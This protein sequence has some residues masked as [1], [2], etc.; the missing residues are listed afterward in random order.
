VQIGTDTKWVSIAAGA[1]HTLGLKSD[2]TQFCATGYNSSGQLGYCSTTSST[3]F[4]C[5]SIPIA[6]PAPTSTTPAAN[7]TICNG[8]NTTLAAT[9]TGTL[10]WY[11]AASAGTYIAGGTSYTTTALSGNTTYYVQDSS[12]CGVA[13][14]TRTAILVTVNSLT[15]T[16]NATATTVCAGTSVTLTGS[17]TATSYSWSGTVT[18]GVGFVPTS[19][20]NTYTVT[21][22]DVNSCTNT[23][24]VSVNVNSLPTVTLGGNVTQC[25][26]SVIL[27][28]GNAGSTYA[29]SPAGTTQTITALSSNTYSVLVTDANNCT[30]TS[31]VNITI[32]TPPTVNLGADV[33]QCGGSVTL[34][35]GNAGSTYAWSPAGTTQTITALATNTYSVVVTDANNCTG[36]NS[37]VVTLHT[38]PTVNLGGNVTQ[39]GGNVILNAG[40]AGSTYAWSPAGTTQTITALSSNTYSVLVTDVNNCTGTSTVNITIHTPPTVNLGADVTQ[41]GGNVT[42]DAGNSGSTYAWSPAG[43]TQ[44]ITALATNTYSVLVTDAN[45][46]TGTSTVNITIHTPPTVNLGADVTQCGGNIILDAEN[47]GSTY[48]WSPA[49]T[50]QTITALATNTYSVLVTDANNCTGTSTVNITFHTP[51]AV[52]LGANVTQCGGNVVLNAGNAG[53]TY[54]WSPAGTTQ[55]ITALTTNT[56]SVVVTDANNCTGTGSKMVTIN[57]PPVV[58]LGANVTQCGGNVILNAGNAG[59][60]YAWSPAGTT[61]M[62]TAFATNTYSVVVTDANSCT[63]T[64]SKMV[65]INTPPVVNLGANVTQCGGNVILNAGNA[66]STYAW[67]PAGTTQMITAFATNTYSVVVTDANSCTGTGSKMVTIHSL[68]AITISSNTT[69]CSGNNAVLTVSGGTMYAWAPSGQ[70]TTSISVTPTANTNY[71]ATVTDANGCSDVATV[72]VTVNPCA[73]VYEIYN[74][75]SLMVYPNPSAGMFTIRSTT[76]GDYYIINSLGEKIQSFKLN[77][78]N[79]YSLNIENLSNGIYFIVGFNDNQMTKQKVVVTK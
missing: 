41:C 79:N 54:A 34:N 62:I 65:T 8:S 18:D 42:L 14:A 53:S 39:C 11:N 17:G 2:R 49:G 9:G 33:T 16:A 32:H 43:T 21:G 22:T 12:A 23:A 71:T 66:G 52:N 46:C 69:I 77:A 51:P 75:H 59:S 57:T 68:P 45:T 15:V 58:N 10:G 25:G 67:S 5:S 50:T 78:A 27:N 37:A 61:Q 76:A 20:S 60:T 70:T 24:T 36:S 4:V 44:T 55:T 29:W 48:A 74:E 6:P 19:A 38:P 47:A 63:G 3:V 28:A 13:S 30:G 72:S 31:T 40:N 73:G 56:Y 1:Y 64:G 7:L 35:A 26:G